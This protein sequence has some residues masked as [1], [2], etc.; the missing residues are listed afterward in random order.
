MKHSVLCLLALLLTVQQ[1]SALE[2]HFWLTD[3]ETSLTFPTDISRFFG[4]DTL[5]GPIRSNDWIA[6]QNDVNGLPVFYVQPVT[7]MPSFRPGSPNPPGQ[8]MGG[9]PIFNAPIIAFPDSLRFLRADALEQERFLFV[10]GHEWYGTIW[11]TQV[12]FY[13]WPVGTPLDTLEAAFLEFPL[14]DY[15]QVFF[16]DGQLDLRGEMFP[17]DCQL[18]LGASG[19][20]RLIDNVMFAGTNWTNGTLPD[21][22]TSRIALASE[23]SIVVAN[24]W[25]NGR[26][27]CS[28]PGGLHDRCN[29]VVTAFIFALRGSFTFEQQNDTD[30]DYISPTQPDERGNLVMTGGITQWRRG[31]VHRSNRGG[32]GYNKRYHY[33]ARLRHW[34][35]GIFEQID[36]WRKDNEFTDVT[37]RLFPAQ[38]TLAVSPNPFNASTT[39][40]YTLPEAAHVRAVVYD[41]TGRAVTE[42]MDET[43]AAGSH[44]LQFDG[45]N[46]SSG[47]YLLR[48][49]AGEQ[50]S[51]HKLLLIK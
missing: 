8:F 28:G 41:V 51:T 42:L 24:T 29:I 30:D 21:G 7:A 13:H 3:G 43:T 50:I 5:W 46:L 26:E 45:A 31:Y 39:I 4:R 37:E 49:A 34:R 11:S 33:D 36:P 47:V 20:I 38:F 40:R 35:T 23:Q 2:N 25:E 22:V 9:P 15:R 1:L 6:T 18:L 12:R 32:T 16:V 44:A 10:E 17:N 14:N 27:N 19:D 48:F